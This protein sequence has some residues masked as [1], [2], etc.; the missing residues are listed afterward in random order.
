VIKLRR[1]RQARHV[2]RV[3]EMINSYEITI[4]NLKERDHSE[5]MGVGRMIILEWIL[6]KWGG[7][8]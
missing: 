4:G 1:K 3:G 2:A 5:G 6:G 8:F 7:K